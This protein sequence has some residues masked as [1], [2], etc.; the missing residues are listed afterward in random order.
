M[1]V[2]VSRLPSGLVVASEI[3]PSVQTVTVGAW[4]R[5]GTRHEPAVINGIAHLLEHMAF[6][7][8]T[9]RTAFDIAAEIEAVGGYLNAYTSRENTAYYARVL[10]GDF[11]LAVD[12]ISDI[13]QFPTFDEMELSRE[14]GV[15]LQ[16]IGQAQDTP[17]D[18]I[19]DHFQEAAFP[20]QALGRP[21]LG[22]A[23]TVAEL[24]RENLIEFRDHNYGPGRMVVA[25]AGAVDHD[26]VLK[27]VT[28]SFD[29]LA[30]RGSE[31]I[32][33]A[34][35]AG[36]EYREERDLEQIHLLIG[37]PS[38]GLLDSDYFAV[39]ILSQILGGGMSSRL[40][41]EVRER[42]GLAYSIYS[43]NSAFSDSGL[44][45]IYAG[46][47][48][49]QAGNLV[50]I[51]AGEL[52]SLPGSMD[53]EELRRAKRQTEA[54]YLMSR[55]ST[56]SRCEHLAQQILTYGRPLPPDEIMGRID[57][58]SMSDVVELCARF[59]ADGPTM[60]SI[61]PVGGLPRLRELRSWLV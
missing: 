28:R 12:V 38:V 7:G 35:Y 11:P 15:V 1:S 5:A 40:Y 22:D 57:Q 23:D 29:S 53:E 39:G 2:T 41:Q 43:F 8:T 32:E 10:Q 55:E 59:L 4:V 16:E 13:L 48:E 21:V 18:I 20:N 52:R 30:T 3:M 42:Q 51:V 50:E 25:A 14:R 9:R 46:T 58:V 24:N 33:A 17:D 6:K 60:A 49:E 37:F 61:G 26:A 36:G 34:R 45:G 27:L 31:E 54:A 19:F 56:T 44:F 47:G